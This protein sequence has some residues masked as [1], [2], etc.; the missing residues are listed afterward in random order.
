MWRVGKSM[1]P[2]RSVPCRPGREITEASQKLRVGELYVG[3]NLEKQAAWMDGRIQQEVCERVVRRSKCRTNFGFVKHFCSVL[4]N[5]L[6]NIDSKS[7][8]T[9]LKF[10]P[11]QV[12]NARKYNK[13]SFDLNHFKTWLYLWEVRV[14]ELKA[15]GPRTYLTIS[16]TAQHLL[17][18]ECS[19]L[20]VVP[21]P[22]KEIVH[23]C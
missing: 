5:K 7:V 6:K 2:E 21:K 23:A 1:Q 15:L 17:P 18:R 16:G 19:S 20:V 8:N 11:K 10:S 22:R 13:Y 3:V 14:V 12:R 4:Q 9:F